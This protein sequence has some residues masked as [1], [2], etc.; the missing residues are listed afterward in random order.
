MIF[1]V[2]IGVWLTLLLLVGCQGRQ[3]LLALPEH[4]VSVP[5]PSALNLT[6]DFATLN[7]KRQHANE[8][9]VLFVF[10][11][12][13]GGSLTGSVNFIPPEFLGLSPQEYYEE[14]TGDGLRKVGATIVEAPH[15]VPI[16]E[17][18]FQR[19]S[20]RMEE[21]SSYSRIYQYYHPESARMLV[22]SLHAE[23]IWWEQEFT[24]YDSVVE[25]VKLNW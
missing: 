20:Y 23:D 3:M 7:P 22:L 4:G 13:R 8:P 15:D 5:Y 11:T 21:G 6:T 25:G 18:T 14:T 1:R 16:G 10:R 9:I 2:Q 24:W 17:R 19:V 12:H